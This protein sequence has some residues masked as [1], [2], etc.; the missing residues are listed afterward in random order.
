[1]SG[2]AND[3]AAEL[4]RWNTPSDPY[5][6]IN[7]R[8]GEVSDEDPY[9][10]LARAVVD[11]EWLAARDRAAAADD[12]VE[13]HIEY[14]DHVGEIVWT[15]HARATGAEAAEKATREFREADLRHQWRAV[16]VRVSE[17]VEEW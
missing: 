9:L 7:G 3:L 2:G 12:H 10:P 6:V 14:A 17:T 11:S 4:F 1:M 13:W 16:R 8:A 15:R 5:F